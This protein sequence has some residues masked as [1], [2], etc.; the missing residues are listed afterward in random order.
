ME[1]GEERRKREWGIE[2]RM[3]DIYPH[4]NMKQ[5]FS[6]SSVEMQNATPKFD[7]WSLGHFI[8]TSHFHLSSERFF[9]KAANNR[10]SSSVD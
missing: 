1:G 10:I 8:S 4:L 7:D 6:D 2:A 9:R 5:S 3:T